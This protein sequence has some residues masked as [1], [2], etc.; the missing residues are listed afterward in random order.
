MR[1][2]KGIVETLE[3]RW[4]DRMEASTLSRNRNLD[5]HG[6]AVD[7]FDCTPL[8]HLP[9]AQGQINWEKHHWHARL[10]SK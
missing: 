3:S 7:A 10:V 1:Y 4:Q 6:N 8:I 9:C 2:I 5:A